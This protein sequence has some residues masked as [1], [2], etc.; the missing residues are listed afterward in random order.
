M[1]PRP[2]PQPVAPRIDDPMALL[3]ACHEKVD[4]F[5]RLAQRLRDHVQ[6]HGADAQAQEAATA[7]LR[8]FTLAA[9]LHHA[10]EDENLF[11]AL[12]ALGRPQL[13]AHIDAL[14]QEHD[15]LGSLWR[16]IQPWLAHIASGQNDRP[17][18][19]EVD[20]F[21]ERYRAHAQQEEALVYPHATD[22]DAATLHALA[23]AMVARRSAPASGPTSGPARVG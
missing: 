6:A 12:R 23:E 9:P 11:T 7:V 5:T 22:L 10:D 19:P 20:T 1:S 2:L 13:N 18:P 16:A 3:R 17:A 21:A 14:Q 8:Y 15:T 4:R